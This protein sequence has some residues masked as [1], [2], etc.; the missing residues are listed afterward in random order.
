[1]Q[2]KFDI[3]FT[4]GLCNMI[5]VMRFYEEI[6]DQEYWTLKYL[7]SENKPDNTWYYRTFIKDEGFY[8]KMSS[9]RPRRRWINL[10]IKRY[11]LKQ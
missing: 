9:K 1:M 11:Q 8:W 5:A 7:V 10:M 4:T 2:S 3:Y 6:T